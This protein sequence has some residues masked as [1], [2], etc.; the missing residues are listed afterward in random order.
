MPD[1]E[2]LR[3]PRDLSPALGE[4]LH[5]GCS[6]SAAGV[7]LEWFKDDVQ[8]VSGGIKVTKS[9][10]YAESYLI[11]INNCGRQKGPSM[12]TRKGGRNVFS[13]WGG[14][15]KKGHCNVKKGH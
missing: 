8:I 12:M 10:F 14:K 5:L 1:L 4:M 6:V 9:S 11:D 2:I 3:A 7:D 15:D 13:F